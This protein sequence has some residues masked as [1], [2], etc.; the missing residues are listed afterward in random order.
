MD[1]KNC[2]FKLPLLN[3]P[4]HIKIIPAD[5]VIVVP[6]RD[7]I[8]TPIV[9]SLANQLS[10]YYSDNNKVHVTSL[11]KCPVSRKLTKTQLRKC[12]PILI[13]ELKLLHPKFVVVFGSDAA[14]VI[15][16]DTAKARLFNVAHY[17]SDIDAH[18]IP[19]YTLDTYQE[20]VTLRH[21]LT[22]NLINVFNSP[23]EKP[24][25]VTI[26]IDEQEIIE[27]LTSLIN[28]GEN[29]FA[30]DVETTGLDIW[31][32]DARVLTCA[33]AFNNQGYAFPI[34]A[35]VN[36]A[37]IV[38]YNKIIPVLRQLMST[39]KVK[40]GH[41][42]KF[43]MN[44]LR[45]IL[46]IKVSMP[47]ADTMIM[48][49]TINEETG[50]HSLS[51]LLGLLGLKD[52]KQFDMSLLNS[53]LP[54]VH[55]LKQLLEYNAK[56]ALATLYLH[57]YILTQMQDNN[58]WVAQ[59]LYNVTFVLH[60]IE[61]HGFAVDVEK[62]KE[63]KEQIAKEIIE[64]EN[65]LKSYDVIQQAKRE[66]NVDDINLNSAQQ[67]A[68]VFELLNLPVI[69]TTQT[70]QISTD[71]QTLNLLAENYNVEFARDLLAY[72]ELNKIMQTYVIPYLEQDIIKD[73]RIHPT[74][75]VTATVSGR[76]SCSNP[77][78]QQIPRN[79][80]IKQ[81][82]IPDNED[83]LL[84]N[85]DYS[86]AELRVMAMLSGDPKLSEA[87][88][89]GIDVHKQTASLVYNKPM[90]E[91]TDEERQLA[92]MVNFAVIYGSSPQ[93]LAKRLN[94]SE[95]EMEAFVNAWFDIYPFVK[96]FEQQI[97]MQARTQGYIMTPFGRVR[98]LSHIN[99]DNIKLHARAERQAINHIIQS[100]AADFTLLSLI[101]IHKLLHGLDAYLVNTVHDSIMLTANKSLLPDLLYKI[102]YVME[103][104]N[105]SWMRG[106]PM[107][108]DISIGKNW[109]NLIELESLDQFEEVVAN[110]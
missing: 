17:A 46:D 93:G 30:F 48:H 29:K 71:K 101:Q 37:T 62:L 80:M 41:N 64:L 68:K 25:R 6:T 63:V 21:E 3:I 11:Y 99:S 23:T 34:Q 36:N 22:S 9:Q 10:I 44:A 96:R 2:E 97:L 24:M 54:D 20:N 69:S 57:D 45:K 1:C 77:N 107:K 66:L 56:D 90:D 81:I 35:T 59:M 8:K 55:T 108:V 95:E 75:N 28:S 78:L 88:I 100:T 5:I 7:Q 82:F 98:H 42:I 92:K 58:K 86:Q 74:Y 14:S 104:Y 72:R 109:G 51:A 4:D 94:R 40:I 83:H 76:L 39:N 85:I 16:D 18:V 53:T 79:A 84:V 47:I 70:G 52:H 43:D 13:Q 12:L 91:V 67:I 65:K 33:I 106:I 105:F 61:M 87:Y 27:L 31:K 103:S 89:K 102:K 19:L 73:G 49:Y 26:L 15:L 32:P 60:D 50:T 110:L 38:D